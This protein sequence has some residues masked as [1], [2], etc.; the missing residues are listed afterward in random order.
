MYPFLRKNFDRRDVNQLADLESYACEY[1][2]EIVK[3]QV[4]AAALEGEALD[5]DDL[6]SHSH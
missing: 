1:G 5:D 2:R 3:P 6:A 4:F